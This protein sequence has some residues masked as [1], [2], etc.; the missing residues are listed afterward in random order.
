MS[1]DV[2]I[3]V[4]VDF[5]IGFAIYVGIFNEIGIDIDMKYIRY[6]EY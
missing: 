1:I 5:D 4:D 6:I 2:G 3:S